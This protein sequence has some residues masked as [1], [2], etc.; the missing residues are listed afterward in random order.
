MDAELPPE[1][2]RLFVK[3][4]VSLSNDETWAQQNVATQLNQSTQTKRKTQGVAMG[5]ADNHKGGKT[6]EAGNMW[7]HMACYFKIKQDI[8]GAGHN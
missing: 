8:L 3:I 7:T 1:E 2:S 4:R 5:G 6:R